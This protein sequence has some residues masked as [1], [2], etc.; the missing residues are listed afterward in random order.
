MRKNYFK[1]LLKIVAISA[2]LFV[3]LS[4]NHGN[5][6]KKKPSDNSTDEKLERLIIKKFTIKDED[7][8]SGNITLKASSIEI[9][10]DN[11]KLEFNQKD[12]PTDFE[13]SPSLPITIKAGEK[14]DITISTPKTQKYNSFTRKVTITCTTLN[15]LT[16]KT[17]TVY[18]VPIDSDYKVN[19]SASLKKVE[20][21]NVVVEFNQS[22]THVV[23]YSGLPITLKA[24]MEHK[25][26]ISTDKTA[27]HESFSRT[28]T[29]V[30]EPIK[31][32]KPTLKKL[33]IHGR[34]ASSGKVNIP[35]D[36]A[37]VENGN[38]ELEFNQTEAPKT[39]KINPST[40]NI[41]AG[42]TMKLTISTDETEKYEAFSF[43]VAV[44]REK[45]NSGQKTIDDCVATL[46]GLLTWNG[47]TAESDIKLPDSVDGFAGST[48]KWTS[49]NDACKIISQAGEIHRNIIDVNVELT[50]EVEWEG[51]RKT[52]TYN[53]T[54]G[55]VKKLREKENPSNESKM[56]DFSTLGMLNIYDEDILVA[57]YEIK[58][59]DLAK[60][61]LKL[62]KN[63]ETFETKLLN[64][65]EYKQ[66]IIDSSSKS[67]KDIFGQAYKSFVKASKITWE[68]FKAYLMPFATNFLYYGQL[69]QEVTD[70]SL[71]EKLAEKLQPLFKG[72][73]ADFKKK[74][75]SEITEEI[76]KGLKAIRANATGEVYVPKNTS[77]DE[78]LDVILTNNKLSIEA[79]V[80]NLFAESI[81]NYTIERTFDNSKYL[82]GYKFKARKNYQSNKRWD[83]Q[84]EVYRKNNDYTLKVLHH[85][86][87][88]KI[89]AKVEDKKYFTYFGIVENNV[90]T[91]DQEAHQMVANITDTKDGKV[92]LNITSCSE[93]SSVGEHVLEYFSNTWAGFWW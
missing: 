14:K 68:E 2:I 35:H 63:K 47:T 88:N 48:V 74:S 25:F 16:L 9:N 3:I 79:L 66:L 28:I 45:E 52:A 59:I 18:G 32:E 39:F 10:K 77:D 41:A 92:T 90:F 17:L 53:F 1:K 62:T 31:K 36:K 8:R 60:K 29:I 67:C 81:F 43:D 13:C 82:D 71:F 64:K 91:C 6:S 7:A 75:E 12:A 51:K 22:G 50:A 85:T 83:E 93:A 57:Q 37:K 11:I 19:L 58:D 56:L 80:D 27:T 84:G 38:V 34:S 70:E 20:E 54:V 24:G 73:F 61:E 5:G 44:T 49:K 72:T 21:K 42:E 65:E 46:E 40:F 69:P 86:S 33:T 78:F 89:V 4:C 15:V 23:K 87:D 26:T 76:K 55:R 30:Y